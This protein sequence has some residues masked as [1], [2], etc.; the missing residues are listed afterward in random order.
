[1]IMLG[2][3]NSQDSVESV[4]AEYSTGAGNTKKEA[5]SN[6]YQLWEEAIQKNK[7]RGFLIIY[8]YK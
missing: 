7:N 5:L 2:R 4:L 8:P 6:M 1:M 3:I